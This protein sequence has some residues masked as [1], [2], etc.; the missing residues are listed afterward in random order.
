[1][2]IPA[3]NRV[4]EP[5]P[6][7]G[8]RPFFEHDAK[9]YFGRDEQTDELLRML[10]R[11][12]FLAVTGTSGSGKSSL[13]RAGLIPS[14]K[15]GYMPGSTAR[16]RVA[17]ARPRGNPFGELA[18]ALGEALGPDEGRDAAL[19]RSSL[20]LV[21]TARP[22]L[23]ERDSLL[24]V[25]DQFEE[26][27][28]FKNE[29]D[30]TGDESD[31]FVK[32]LL[33]AADQIETPVYV[34]LTMRSDYLGDCS[35][36]RGLPEAL[37]GSQYLVPVLTRPQL[38]EAIERPAQARGVTIAPDLAQRLLNDV[39]HGLEQELDQLPVLQHA[40]MR[41]WTKAEG[42]ELVEMRHYE[43]AGKMAG[44]L[45]QHADELYDAL[46]PDRRRI[47]RKL[48]QRLTEKE[49]Q[50][51][52]IRRATSFGEL[53]RLTNASREETLAVV[54]HF[55]GFLAMPAPGEM[56]DASIVDIT[57]EA[58]IRQWRRLRGWAAEEAEAARIYHRLADDAGHEDADPWR[59]ARLLDA[60]KLKRDEGWN[61]TWARRY[62]ASKQGGEEFRAVEAF[63]DRGVRAR[64]RRYLVRWAAAAAVLLAMAAGYWYYVEQRG[65]RNAL[66]EQLDL[67]VTQLHDSQELVG[68]L[69]SAVA[70]LAALQERARQANDEALARAL[71]EQ[72]RQF[73]QKIKE[74]QE[75]NKN[76]EG[77]VD[78]IN[79]ELKKYQQKTAN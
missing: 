60:V 47:A 13:V 3:K 9:W 43:A 36:F 32:L 5:C 29:S 46:S 79:E 63:L 64:K 20:G 77:S 34:V 26:I 57:H 38:R 4:G 28:R 30:A 11:K 12:R 53:T 21:E 70:D 49:A 72:Q 48:F 39:G 58:L 14:L 2:T 52:D 31:A 61:D 51:R 62:A 33:A 27:F 8:L 78:R 22:S 41:T 37:N 73:E 15:R 74:R 68:D 7:L 6:Y 69:K 71:R 76:Y 10:G 19:R 54:E 44:A 45:D 17:V 25:I 75:A 16:W 24:V 42:A 65:R 50:G 23:E 1:M 40:L 59:G 18:A 66:Q 35:V 67:A 55:R 56:R